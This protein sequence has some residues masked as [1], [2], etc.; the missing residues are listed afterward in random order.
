M[1]TADFAEA[2]F[3]GRIFSLSI[4]GPDVDYDDRH[5]LP[6]STNFVISDGEIAEGTFTATLTGTDDDENADLANSLRGYAGD[7]SGQFYGPKA[8]E[9]G[10]VVTAARTTD[11]TDDWTMIGYLGATKERD[12]AI[13]NSEQLSAF[14]HRDWTA[15]TTSPSSATAIVRPITGGYRITFTTQDGTQETVEYG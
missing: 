11:A 9:F 12:I 6:D 13:D 1:L 4:Q 3:E 2:A 10:A 7:V 5:H 8:R 15:E 14:I